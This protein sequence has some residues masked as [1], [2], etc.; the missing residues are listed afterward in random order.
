ML[1]VS[2]ILSAKFNSWCDSI[3]SDVTGCRTCPVDGRKY[4]IYKGLVCYS[5]EQY[6]YYL[7]AYEGAGI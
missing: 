2:E 7:N 1:T 3:P 6:E 5:Y 4:W